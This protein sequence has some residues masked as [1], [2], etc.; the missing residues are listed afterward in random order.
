MT[1]LTSRGPFRPSLARFAL[2]AC[3]AVPALSACKDNSVADDTAADDSG[4]NTEDGVSP[5]ITSGSAI[6]IHHTTGDEAY[7]WTFELQVDDPQGAEDLDPNGDDDTL[8]HDIEIMQ[9]GGV[10]DEANNILVCNDEGTCFG[11]FNTQVYGLSC[12]DPTVYTFRFHVYDFDG[13]EGTY[14]AVGEAG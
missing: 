10:I 11:S 13:N 12:S 14:D 2:A 8:G 6:C 7:I 1:R 3:L 4:S 9:N 5:E